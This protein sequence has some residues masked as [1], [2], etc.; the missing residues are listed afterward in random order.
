MAGD[1][2][3]MFDTHINYTIN[4]DTMKSKNSIKVW[5]GIY[6]SDISSDIIRP[7]MVNVVY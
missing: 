3:F 5:M 4:G 6:Y 7:L 1:K 2:R